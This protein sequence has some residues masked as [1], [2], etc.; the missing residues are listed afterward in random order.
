MDVQMGLRWFL[1]RMQERNAAAAAS[2]PAAP[3]PSPALPVAELEPTTPSHRDRAP[4][5]VP[6]ATPVP[7][8]DLHHPK[9]VAKPTKARRRRM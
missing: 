7:D 1:T 2:R 5:R 8:G 3:S 6:K 4:R 9:Y